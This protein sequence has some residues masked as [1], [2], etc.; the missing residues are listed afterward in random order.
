[1]PLRR[2]T[3]RAAFSYNVRELYHANASKPR[4]KKRSR[5]QILAIAYAMKRRHKA[6]RG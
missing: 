1:M 5:K 3:S 6:S 4:G 2:G